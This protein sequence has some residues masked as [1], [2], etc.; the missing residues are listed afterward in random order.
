MSETI[1]RCGK[2]SL[3]CACWEGRLSRLNS[4][5][6][7][8]VQN[9]WDGGEPGDEPNS[10]FPSC[11]QE[12][13]AAPHTL[14]NHWQNSLPPPSRNLWQRE[15]S[16]LQPARSSSRVKSASLKHEK[17]DIGKLK[18]NTAFRK[19]QTKERKLKRACN[20]CKGITKTLTEWALTYGTQ[21]YNPVS[22]FVQ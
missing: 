1:Q 11:T 17:H 20:I 3:D 14:W 22:Y 19:R 7:C 18:K 5:K 13:H 15:S 8:D 21:K 12:T 2:I 10:V 4:E 6:R 9:W 16:K